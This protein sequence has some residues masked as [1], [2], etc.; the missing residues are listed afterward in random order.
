MHTKFIH[1]YF[2]REEPK[3]EE[4]DLTLRQFWE[5]EAVRKD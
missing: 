5:I 4:I 1:A 2:V 3:L